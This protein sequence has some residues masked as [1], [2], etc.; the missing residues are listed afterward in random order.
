MLHTYRFI[1]G[2]GI[3]GGM[4]SSCD[5]AKN[6]A[7]SATEDTSKVEILDTSLIQEQNSYILPSPVQITNIYQKAGLRFIDGLINPLENK[8]KY[9]TSNS[10]Y[11]NL[12]VYGADLAY[13]ILNEHTQLGMNYLKVVKEISNSLGIAG[14][15]E[16]QSLVSR[17][18][19][20]L[21]NRDSLKVLLVEMNNDSKAFL[22]ENDKRDQSYLI[23]AA[24]WLESYYLATSVAIKE[25]KA[26]LNTRIGQQKLMLERMIM[27][28]TATKN[29][30]ANLEKLIQDF[31]DLNAVISDVAY[32]KSNK[33]AAETSLENIVITDDEML[34]INQK[35]IEIRNK[36]IAVN[37]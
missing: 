25:K 3:I 14:I 4:L 36:I 32:F 19:K 31:N 22:E 35:T 21:G 12:G 11:L 26:V 20:N 27:L 13:C 2:F 18:E 9:T 8:N 17:F 6:N 7:P 1:V 16:T 24:G 37:K 33:N 28:L 23:F 15:L 5:N 29:R 34:L 30:D 10:K